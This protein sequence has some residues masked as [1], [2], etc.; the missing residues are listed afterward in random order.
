M[1]PANTPTPEPSR[2]DFLGTI[3]LGAAGAVAA[4]TTAAHVAET[5]AETLVETLADK[6]ILQEKKPMAHTLPDLP[7]A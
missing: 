2:R 6:T 1:T 7:Y 4:S 5:L 3:A